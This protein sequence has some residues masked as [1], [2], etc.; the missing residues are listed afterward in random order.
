[1]KNREIEGDKARATDLSTFKMNIDSRGLRH[2]LCRWNEERDTFRAA[3]G[4]TSLFNIELD[5]EEKGSLGD[6]ERGN[7][8]EALIALW[9]SRFLLPDS[10]EDTI[11]SR[12]FPLVIK[13]TKGTVFPLTSL[14]LGHLYSQLEALYNL[15]WFLGSG[16]ILKTYVSTVF[17]Q[18][19]MW[20]RFPKYAPKPVEVQDISYPYSK[21]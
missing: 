11:L 5:D 3:V 10:P 14:V 16:F 7:T 12:Y 9:L 19:F 20:E 13:I 6:L 18:D 21:L 1:M 17:L 2:L 8:V 15:E 4:Q